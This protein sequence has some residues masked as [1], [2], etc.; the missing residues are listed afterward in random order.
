MP[1]LIVR[2]IR[3]RQFFRFEAGYQNDEILNQ[4]PKLNSIFYDDPRG[5]ENYKN[6]RSKHTKLH[7]LN[8]NNK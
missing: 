7:I 6:K 2:D 5:L 4:L 8:T 3:Y 1:T